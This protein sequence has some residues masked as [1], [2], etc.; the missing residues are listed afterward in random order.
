MCRSFRRRCVFIFNKQ[1]IG[2]TALGIGVGAVFGG[3]A[4]AIYMGSLVYGVSTGANVIYDAAN[5]GRENRR[6]EN[7]D[8]FGNQKG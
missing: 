4:G 5:E 3:P 6:S 1:S 8:A 2:F 7:Y